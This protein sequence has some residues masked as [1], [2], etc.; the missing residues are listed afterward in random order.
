M[1]IVSRAMRLCKADLHGVMDRM[2][3]KDLLLRQHLREMEAAMAERRAH[4]ARL[5]ETLGAGRRDLAHYEKQLKALETELERAVARNRDDV[6]RVL[7]RRLLPLRQTVENMAHHLNTMAATLDEEQSRLGAQRLAYHETR[8]RVAMARGRGWLAEPWP[9]RGL[10]ADR[11]PS[12]P[13][14]EEIE[15][16]LLQYKDAAE[17]GRSS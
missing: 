9:D 15:W 12:V 13:S 1:G 6:A 11:H 10:A 4:T 3:D 5:E 17:A 7:I 14:E 2:E 16:E 8:H